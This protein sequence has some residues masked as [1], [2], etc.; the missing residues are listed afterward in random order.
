MLGSQ[1]E[2]DWSDEQK[3]FGAKGF[4]VFDTVKKTIE[5]V[6]NPCKLHQEIVYLNGQ[7]DYEQTT[8]QIVR[9][10]VKEKP[11]QKNFDKFINIIKDEKPYKLDIIDLTLAKNLDVAAIS[12]E[13][14]KQAKVTDLIDSYVSLTTIPDALKPKVTDYL[15]E[16]HW[17]VTQ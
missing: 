2:F 12:D 6:P 10:V 11:S 3:G 1:Y 8:D 9:I 17:N 4:H 15:K 7:I 5:F 13:A 16:L 14:L